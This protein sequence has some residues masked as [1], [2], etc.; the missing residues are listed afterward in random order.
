MPWL[1]LCTQA[2]ISWGL[3]ASY[4]HGLPWYGTALMTATEPWSGRSALAV[5]L[6]SL[7]AWPIF[8]FVCVCCSF[9][10]ENVGM[11]WATAHTTHFTEP[12]W[13]YLTVGSGSG[14]LAQGG[15]Y[16]T[17]VDGN[18]GVTVVIEKMA[19]AHSQCI[20]PSIQQVCLCVA[21]WLRAPQ[22]S[23]ACCRVG[24]AVVVVQYIK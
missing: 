10:A 15:S 11:L 13:R 3:I 6:Y 18:G 4:Y 20:R 8:I 19:W 9:D 2:T 23:R 17:L 14:L 21:L 7:P 1:W 12:G 5:A 24:G 16:V 22:R